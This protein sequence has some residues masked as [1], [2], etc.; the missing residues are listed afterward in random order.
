MYWIKSINHKLYTIDRGKS[1][2][3]MALYLQNKSLKT[4]LDHICCHFQQAGKTKYIQIVY[5]RCIPSF[6]ICVLLDCLLRQIIN[7]TLNLSSSWPNVFR[8]RQN[9]A[10]V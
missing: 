2:E 3:F 1:L 10:N 9:D 4:R 8:K 5:K 7:V 6:Y